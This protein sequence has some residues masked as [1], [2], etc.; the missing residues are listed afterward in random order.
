MSSFQSIC[1]KLS[2]KLKFE[3]RLELQWPAEVSIEEET[4]NLYI[5]LLEKGLLIFLDQLN[6]N[7]EARHKYI[8]R[9][10]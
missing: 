5:I 4:C 3:Q 1:Y 8:H 10:S 6:P 2:L 7:E 9:Q